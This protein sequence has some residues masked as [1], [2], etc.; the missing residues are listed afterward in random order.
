MKDLFKTYAPAVFLLIGF[1]G[2]WLYGQITLLRA[3]NEQMAVQL[4]G[5]CEA[6][7]SKLG[8]ELTTP[9]EV[10]EAAEAKEEVV[11]ED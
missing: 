5:G 1:G 11:E 8:W 6:T 2:Y 4:A 7:L 3:I 9:A 10:A